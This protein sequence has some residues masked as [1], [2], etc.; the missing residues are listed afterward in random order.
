MNATIEFHCNP[1][2]AVPP[3]PARVAWLEAHGVPPKLAIVNVE[4]PL[5]LWERAGAYIN[6]NGTVAP[7]GYGHDIST[8]IRDATFAIV[9]ETGSAPVT[10]GPEIL[11]RVVE[12]RARRNAERAE[13]DRESN[14][15]AERE[16]A[17]ALESQIVRALALPDT[18]WIRFRTDLDG[19]PDAVRAAY[20][21]DFVRDTRVDDD[22][23]ILACRAALEASLPTRRDRIIAERAANGAGIDALLAE[24]GTPSQ[25]Q[26]HA[27]GV[28]PP[29]ELTGLARATWLPVLDLALYAPLTKQDLNHNDSCLDP[30]S[31]FASRPCAAGPWTATEWDVIREITAAH[32][33]VEGVSVTPMAHDLDCPECDAETVRYGV[34]VSLTRYGLTVKREYALPDA[35][36][37]A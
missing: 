18:E 12:A 27:A 15:R 1:L 31:R 24:Y 36:A 19:L 11:D 23:R 25:I 21:F 5:A 3:S 29:D 10:L 26:R 37:T 30:R 34:R 9:R 6:E 13:L 16:R 4:A 35:T 7:L 14:D 22:P 20:S 32:A 28:L 8:A 2:D 17:G 33:G